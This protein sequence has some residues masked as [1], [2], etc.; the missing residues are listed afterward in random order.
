MLIA[1]VLSVAACSQANDDDDDDDD[2]DFKG[3]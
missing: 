1:F 3:L 2:D